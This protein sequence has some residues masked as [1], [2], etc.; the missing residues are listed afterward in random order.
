MFFLLNLLQFSLFLFLMV[1]TLVLN[2]RL[3]Y[4][5]VLSILNFN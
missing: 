3:Y 4:V 1:F 5:A 2:S